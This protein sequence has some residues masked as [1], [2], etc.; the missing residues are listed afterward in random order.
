MSALA[1]QLWQD[2]PWA[3]PRCRFT[4]HAIRERCRNCGFDS[5]L[6]SGDCYFPEGAETPVRYE[7]NETPAESADE[8][9][10]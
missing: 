3:C 6:V 1:E 2:P 7:T 9:G 4:N 5:A 10:I 8:K